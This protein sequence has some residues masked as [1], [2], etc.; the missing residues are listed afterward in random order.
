M[1]KVQELL[2]KVKLTSTEK[3]TLAGGVIFVLYTLFL[4]NFID[5]GTTGFIV[6]PAVLIWMIGA[7]LLLCGVV[8]SVGRIVVQSYERL[9][10]SSFIKNLINWFCTDDR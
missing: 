5:V 4:R 6:I 3:F 7:V 2:G 8:I 10:E 1:N 9:S